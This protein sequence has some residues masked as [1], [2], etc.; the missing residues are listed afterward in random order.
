M[1]TWNLRPVFKARGIEKPYTF[2][3]KAGIS[4][5]TATSILSSSTCVMRLNHLE[6]ICEKLNCT[7]HDIMLWKPDPGKQLP[8]SH[9]LLTLKKDTSGFD[10]SE[11]LKTI[12]L[13]KLNEIAR[14]LSSQNN[15]PQP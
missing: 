3:V 1:L 5:H 15:S 2:L 8:E 4:P 12:P 13:E 10:L 14:L 6:L 9:Q 7:P 11:T